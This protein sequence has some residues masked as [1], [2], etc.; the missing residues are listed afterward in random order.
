M[1]VLRFMPQPLYPGKRTM[2][3]RKQPGFSGKQKNFCSFQ[4]SNPGHPSSRLLSVL[5]EL[6][7]GLVKYINKRVGE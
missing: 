2:D 4:E 1:G 6:S 5:T 7:L 3:R